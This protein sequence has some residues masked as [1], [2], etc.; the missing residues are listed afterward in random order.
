MDKCCVGSWN[1]ISQIS[2]LLIDTSWKF[3]F[4]RFQFWHCRMVCSRSG[5]AC[6]A[7]MVPRIR[8][9]LPDQNPK[10][11]NQKNV[12]TYSISQKLD[13][14]MNSLGPKCFIILKRRFCMIFYEQFRYVE[15]Q[16]YSFINLYSMHNNGLITWKWKSVCSMELNVF[17]K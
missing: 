13:I 5:R 8:Q 4:I 3:D 10:G 9:S 17:L 14:I 7:A 16:F 1:S 6:S 11:F 2:K 15:K 12:T